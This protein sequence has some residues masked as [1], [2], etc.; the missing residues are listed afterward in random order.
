[1]NDLRNG[2]IRMVYHLLAL[3]SPPGVLTGVLD[4]KNLACQIY[5]EEIIEKLM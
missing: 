2:L 5:L 4:A 3:H 1:M